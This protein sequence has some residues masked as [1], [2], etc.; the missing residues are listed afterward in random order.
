MGCWVRMQLDAKRGLSR[1]VVMPDLRTKYMH[2]NNNDGITRNSTKD[3]QT[4]MAVDP[5]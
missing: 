3:L 5:D 1:V 2:H 4:R